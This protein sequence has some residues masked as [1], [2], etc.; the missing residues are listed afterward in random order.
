M[1]GLVAGGKG[2]VVSLF[3]KKGETSKAYFLVVEGEMDPHR[4]TIRSAHETRDAAVAHARDLTLRDPPAFGT[5]HSTP[6]PHRVWEAR[7]TAD[8]IFRRD[9]VSVSEHEE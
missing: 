1:G 5:A 2:R 9:P 4:S 7:Y 8:V 3:L 6:K